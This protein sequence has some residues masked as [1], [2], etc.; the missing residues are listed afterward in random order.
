VFLTLAVSAAVALIMS[1]AV[2]A[3]LLRDGPV[4]A[5]I[6]P[7]KTHVTPTP[8]SGG[9]GIALGMAGGLVALSIMMT[10][11]Y[12]AI[13]EEGAGLMTTVIAFAYI[14]L[15]IGFLDDARPLS[16]RF[17]FV[18][19]SAVSVGAAAI[20]GPVEYFA[21]LPDFALHV[22]PWL[23]LI[24]TALWIF[25]LVNCV[26]FMDGSNGLSMGSLAVGLLMLGIISIGANRL[27]GAAIGFCGAGAIVGFLVFNFPKGRL[28][29]GDAGA[30]F[31]GAVAALGSVLLIH[32]ADLSPFVPAILFFPLLAD[33]LLTLL[34]RMG[35]GRS[36]LDGHSEHLYQIARRA[37]WS[38]ARVAVV[39]WIA[40]AVCGMI[41]YTVEDMGPPATWLALAG[42]AVIALAISI[43]VRRWA[44]E[45]GIAEA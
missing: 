8:T 4:D 21:L 44:L 36:L 24:G 19:F 27:T 22:G 32:R 34:W 23:G 1:F 38:H 41:A 5:P 29:A 12:L 17:K 9:L 42:L 7:H 37:G 14:F 6:E 13:S 30:L 28:F 35:R 15:L 18:L 26:N 20:A 25:T 45:R 43:G 39:Y 31:G 16:A 2:C 10:I 33:A 11:G 3:A 40:T